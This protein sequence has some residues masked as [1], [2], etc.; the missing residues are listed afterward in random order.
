MTR[1]DLGESTSVQGVEDVATGEK[2]T[3]RPPRLA[4]GRAWYYTLVL[5]ACVFGLGF[6][7]GIGSEKAPISEP[8]ELPRM[9]QCTNDWINL[10]QPKEPPS[11]AIIK[12][13]SGQCYAFIREQG[14]LDDFAARN[15]AY[16]QQGYANRV[17]LWMVVLITFSGVAL[18]AIQLITTYHFASTSQDYNSKSDELVFQRDR[19]ILKSSVTGLFILLISFAFFLVFVAYVYRLDDAGSYTD[20]H[21]RVVTLPDVK[22]GLLS[23]ATVAPSVKPPSTGTGVK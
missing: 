22:S 4:A 11:V 12:E 17:I 18:A 15:V 8:R 23:P 20:T 14:L 3:T 9:L 7:I 1:T 21:P 16:F 13:I 6:I 5:S 10:V 19:V 2:P